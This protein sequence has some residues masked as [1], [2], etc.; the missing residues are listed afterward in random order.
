MIFDCDGTLVDSEPLS[1]EAWR[2]TL[3]PYGY[4]VTDADPEACVG[5]AYTRTHA[6]LAERV[7]F[8]TGGAFTPE[9]RRFLDTVP[10]QRLEK[11]FDAQ[12][13]RALVRASLLSRL[14]TQV[15]S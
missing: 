13:V 8:I 9:A 14:G 2:R 4:T 11:P 15:P 10:N 1:G 12:Q 3:A 6:Y 5:V 7:V